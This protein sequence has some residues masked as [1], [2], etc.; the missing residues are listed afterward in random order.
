MQHIKVATSKDTTLLPI[1]AFFMN[2]PDW[3]LANIRGQLQDYSLRKSIL[4]FHNTMVV[5]NDDL[6]RR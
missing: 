3:A 1:L 5:P 2:G 6:L 4:Y